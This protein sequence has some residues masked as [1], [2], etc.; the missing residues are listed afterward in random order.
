M[1][2]CALIKIT[3][4]LVIV[5]APSMKVLAVKTLRYQIVAVQIT[6]PAGTE[7]SVSALMIPSTA[8]VLQDIRVDCVQMQK[9]LFN[10]VLLCVGRTKCVLAAHHL[11]DSLVFAV[12]DLLVL[13]VVQLSLLAVN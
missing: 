10:A 12:K 11:G 13:L 1:E 9:F 5:V 7:A 6:V 3:A 8:F 4:I 2:D